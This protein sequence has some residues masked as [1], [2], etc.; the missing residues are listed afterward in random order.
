MKK[1]DEHMWRKATRYCEKR[2]HNSP[3]KLS[4]DVFVSAKQQ[5]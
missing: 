1:E 5:N 2:G 3:I 4:I